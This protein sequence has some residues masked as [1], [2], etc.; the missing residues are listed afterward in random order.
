MPQAISPI[1]DI[2]TSAN[3]Y[4]LDQNCYYCSVAALTGRTV[5]DFF[6]LFETMQRDAATTDGIVGLH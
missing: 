1:L 5:E 4:G 6:Q 3:T 2:D